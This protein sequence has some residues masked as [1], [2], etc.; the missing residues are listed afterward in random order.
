MQPLSAPQ[1]QGNWATL[2]LPIDDSDR[3]DAAALEAE[4]EY[5]VQAGVDGIYSNGT[6][7]EFY[8]QT[9]DE[10]NY[11]SELLAQYCHA[12]D[13]PFQLGINHTNPIVTLE[14]VKRVKQL[15]PGALQVILPDWFPPTLSEAADFLACIGMAAAPVGVVLYNPPHAKRQLSLPEI[16]QLAAQVPELVGVKLADGGD[17]WYA[18][19][20]AHL[21][22]LSVFIP[23]HHVATGIANGAAGSYSNVAC[24]SPRG[25]QRWTE[26]ARQDLTAA[27]AL[28]VRV[29]EFMT[30]HVQP[31]MTER[32]YSNQAMD[33]M[34]AAIGNWA[35]ISAR[36]R[37]PYRG[38]DLQTVRRLRAVAQAELPEFF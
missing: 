6:A 38:V 8:N 20:R 32:G 28:E 1:I 4:L 3:I 24:L 30:K 35:P 12:H 25:A 16:R 31:L 29:C 2:L 33:K 7:G 14:R 15:A 19:M 9:E 17:G 23:G 22:D 34:M 5:L 27:L 11:I 36:L 18:E 13:V 10:F 21:A 26:L 37:W